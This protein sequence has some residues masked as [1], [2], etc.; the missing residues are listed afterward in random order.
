MFGEFLSLFSILKFVSV[1]PE[2]VEPSNRSTSI[3]LLVD[4]SV[5]KTCTSALPVENLILI[6]AFPAIG[7]FKKC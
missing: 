5:G 6:V 7:I 1:P 3:A 4:M 2:N